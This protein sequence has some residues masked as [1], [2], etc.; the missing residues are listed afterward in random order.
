[1]YPAEFLV[2]SLFPFTLSL[3]ALPSVTNPPSQ[4]A[5][6]RGAAIRGL[7]GA[8]PGTLIC[9]RHYGFK[10]GMRFRE[11]IDDEAYAY[12]HFGVK[13]CSGF[14]EW[15]VAKVCDFASHSLAAGMLQHKMWL[16]SNQQGDELSASTFK[17]V[18]VAR[19]WTPGSSYVF[20]FTLYSSTADLAPSREEEAGQFLSL[21]L[22]RKGRH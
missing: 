19:V 13:H 18:S 21:I 12:D 9:R 16:S 14:M 2:W 6:V 1:M 7:E 3:V 20:P 8:I 4:A 17:M 11:G 22:V 15:M 5:V 10:W